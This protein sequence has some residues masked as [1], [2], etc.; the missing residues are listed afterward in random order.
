M[1]EKPESKTLNESGARRR[2]MG[3]REMVSR[4]LGGAG[5]SYAAPL[6][7]AA[8]PVR[9][10]LADSATLAQAD[11][12]AAEPNWKPLFLDAHQTATFEVLAERIVPGSGEAKVTRFV[13]LLLSVDTQENQKKFLASLGAFE[14]E[15]I[16]RYARPYK[17]LT[18]SQQ[19][20]LLT[21]ASGS[22]HGGEGNGDATGLKVDGHFQNLK[23]WVSG[24]YYSSEHGMR[25]L[26]WDGQV[27][28]ASFPGCQRPEDHK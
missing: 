23:G 18:E 13:D 8:H 25:E 5:L 14:A 11:A 24:A 4:L 27:I 12:K 19:N 6:V 28:F 26:G 9:K 17:E 1:E 22:E 10:H 21:V 7:A 15:S 3:R 2:A 16:R 20:E